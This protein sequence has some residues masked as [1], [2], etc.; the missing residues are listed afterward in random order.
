MFKEKV[1]VFQNRIGNLKLNIDAINDQLFEIIC[2]D[3]DSDKL[4]DIV[5]SNN[6]TLI[7]IDTNLFTDDEEAF[8]ELRKLNTIQLRKKL[9]TQFDSPVSLNLL[10]DLFSVRKTLELNNLLIFFFIDNPGL[11]LSQEI[12]MIGA[13]WVWPH[14]TKHDETLALITEKLRMLKSDNT[15]LGRIL[16]IEDSYNDAD[17]IKAHLEDIFDI[18][19]IGSE[20]PLG[21]RKIDPRATIE[22]IMEDQSKKY[23]AII[24]DLCLDENKESESKNLYLKS[25]NYLTQLMNNSPKRIK[26]KALELLEGLQIILAV[27]NSDFSGLIIGF[28]NYA[29]TQEFQGLVLKLLNLK[30][31]KLDRILFLSKEEHLEELRVIL[32]NN[33]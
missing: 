14:E 9:R 7:F 30:D 1:L 21:F 19:H 12:M 23:C 18:D 26:E 6:P 4:I 5:K 31:D 8:N 28:S 11:I 22:K 24:V 25:E 27:S 3:Y 33:L 15:K 13:D 32:Q 10:K 29:V 20:Q 17:D 16:L 2:V